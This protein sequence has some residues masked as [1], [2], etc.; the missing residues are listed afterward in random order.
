MVLKVSAYNTLGDIKSSTKNTKSLLFRIVLRMSKSH[1]E[2]HNTKS[3]LQVILLLVGRNLLKYLRS[4]EILQNYFDTTQ[5][6]A[7]FQ[8]RCLVFVF[9]P[10]FIH[11]TFIVYVVTNVTDDQELKK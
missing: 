1:K 2:S 6:Y 4:V 10:R 8:I 5:Y 11:C 9:H 7:V 3:R